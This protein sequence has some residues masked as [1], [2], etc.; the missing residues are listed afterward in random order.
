VIRSFDFEPGTTLASKYV[1]LHRL[2]SGWEGE[3]YKIRERST[4]IERAAKAFYPQRNVNQRAVRFQARKLHKLSKCP[5]LIHYHT[6]ET[7]DCEG[8]PVTLL[9]SDYVEGEQLY[10]FLNRQRGKRVDPILGLQLLHSMAAALESVHGFGEY[11]GDLHT[12][13]IIVRR[14]GLGFDIRLIDFF[15]QDGSRKENR[16]CDLCELVRVFYDAIGG[17]KWYSKH[18]PEIKYICCGLKRSLILSRFKTVRKLRVHLET[19][20]WS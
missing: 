7:I 15:H 19:I 5:V 13:N 10:K 8:T 16:D 12:D 9:I 18:P 6:A 11:H 20:E 14:R 3:V 1:V 2:G 4:G 17:R